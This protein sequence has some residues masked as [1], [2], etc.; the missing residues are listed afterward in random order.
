MVHQECFSESF[1]KIEGCQVGNKRYMEV[2]VK[3]A[4]QM[5][6]V[7]ERSVLN[8]LRDHR[9]KGTKV[10]K[11]W[12]VDKASIESFA[13]KH[14]Y[15]IY[16]PETGLNYFS[17]SGAQVSSS[18]DEIKTASSK[19]PTHPTVQPHFVGD[20]TREVLHHQQA[21]ELPDGKL[22]KSV[23]Y[24]VNSKKNK[25]LDDL[26]V[27]TL[28]RATIAKYPEYFSHDNPLK[29]KLTKVLL[30]VVENLGAGFYAYGSQTKIKYYLQ[31][32]SNIGAFLALTRLVPAPTQHEIKIAFEFEDIISPAM[33][34]LIRNLEKRAF[35]GES[36]K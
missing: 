17:V 19:T 22:Q 4:S 36:R 10:G 6:R 23:L 12:F 16:E 35:K 13:I 7:T 30:N 8:Y 26:R 14:G 24:S 5:L 18:V 29:E 9:I 21:P 11:E 34:A 27:L 33:I 28:I 32:R 1:R 15:D 20:P 2:N 31:A 3:V 25:T